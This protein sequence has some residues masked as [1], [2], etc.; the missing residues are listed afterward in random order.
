M[1]GRRISLV[2]LLTAFA[3]GVVYWFAYGRTLTYDVFADGQYVYSE[4]L[5]TQGRIIITC[6]VACLVS[7]G[8]LLSLL[9][10]RGAIRRRHGG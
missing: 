2:V 3:S 6:V 9:L 8:S 4:G 7:L 1:S 10:V 5:S